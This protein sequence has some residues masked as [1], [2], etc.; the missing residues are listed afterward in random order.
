MHAYDVQDPASCGREACT[1]CRG[2]KAFLVRVP[3]RQ[4]DQPLCL[5]V[6]ATRVRE[7]MEAATAEEE[8]ECAAYEA[9][10]Q[11]LRQGERAAPVRPGAGLCLATLC[12][13]CV[14]LSVVPKCF[15]P[16]S[17]ELCAGLQAC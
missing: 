16:M 8:A 1:I 12:S 14:K 11:R 7:E 10:L 15:G 6:C 9:A 4:V 17:P 3:T 13:A 2:L 5:R